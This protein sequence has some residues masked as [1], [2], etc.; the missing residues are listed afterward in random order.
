ME[1]LLFQIIDWDQYHE[2]SNNEDISEDD[3]EKKPKLEDLEYK[4]RLFGRQKM[5]NQYM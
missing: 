2:T 1:E 5:V 3:T 4:I